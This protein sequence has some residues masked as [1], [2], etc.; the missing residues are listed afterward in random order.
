M[1]KGNKAFKDNKIDIEDLGRSKMI[2]DNANI[3]LI[4]EQRGEEH[5]RED[6]P[7]HIVK[8]RDG[9]KGKVLLKK[10]FDK[11]RITSF[12]DD[13]AENLGDENEI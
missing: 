10:E 6:M 9:P 3:V 5:L 1:S 11:S 7:I 2:G 12:P 13:W 8:N 4:I